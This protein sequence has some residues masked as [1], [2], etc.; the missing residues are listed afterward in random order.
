MIPIH[1]QPYF[2]LLRKLAFYW[3]P[4]SQSLLAALIAAAAVSLA[5]VFIQVMLD[6]AFVQKD[7]VLLQTALL[8]IIALF[9]ARAIAGFYGAL[10]MLKAGGKL[11]IDLYRAFFDKLL[12][13]PANA[14]AHLRE[15]RQIEAQIFAIR[16]IMQSTVRLIAGSVQDCLIIA[17]LAICLLYLNRELLLLLLF[18]APFMVLIVSAARDHFD[19]PNQKIASR[20]KE[21]ID[22][23]SQSIANYRVIK[24]DRG[25]GCE[26]ERL[27]KIS[28]S[29]SQ[30]ETQQALTKAAAISAG[31]I[32]TAL[33]LCALG[34]ITVLQTMNGT[35]SLTAAG[36][37][38]AA[39][40]L[41]ILPVLRLINLPRQL[42]HD[43]KILETVFTFIDQPSEQYAGTHSMP[44]TNCK[45]VFEDVRFDRTAKTGSIQDF[46]NLTVMPGEVVVF[47][48][49][50]TDKKNALIDLLLRLES[51]SSGKIFLGGHLLDEINLDDLYA[52]ITLL[53][54][55]PL[56]LDDKIAGNI[57]YGA[58]RCAHE[59][60]ITAAAR[61]SDAMAFIREM[62]GGLQTPIGEKGVEIT[63]RQLQFLAI[64]RA[65]VKNAPLL[66]L[67]EFPAMQDPDA[68]ILL[69]ALERLMQNRTTLIFSRQIP[70]LKKIDRIIE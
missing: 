62:P 43:Q 41:L 52:N 53:P 61:N 40:L 58:M 8:T 32:A 68:E 28:E 14:Y 69:S 31:Q 54:A 13:L 39:I 51:P 67:D 33:I 15:D 46:I 25:Y 37:T 42:A 64:A 59:A 26:S 50:D 9:V 70:P 63:R 60:E 18:V 6:G 22:R 21:L 27:G 4:V 1:P 38:L 23:L 65:L 55:E 30:A 35:L 34:Y 3:K 20:T 44:R 19:T 66:I 36:A 57:A 12:T 16:H 29:I 56:L 2:R 48:G 7:P 17:G 47:K 49:Y 45:L 24:V 11:E 5:P 10:S